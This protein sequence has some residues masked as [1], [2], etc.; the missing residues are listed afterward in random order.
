MR[1]SEQLVPVALILADVVPTGICEP[2][3]ILQIRRCEKWP[4]SES[5]GVVIALLD[6]VNHVLPI[7]RQQYARHCNDST[8]EPN[9]KGYALVHGVS[10]SFAASAS[11]AR[12]R[13]M[14]MRA[15]SASSISL[16][17]SAAV[18]IAGSSTEKSAARFF[19]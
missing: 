15:V 5:I 1:H 7:E 14:R 8:D 11:N 10:G 18:S 16:R 12:L 6:G 13:S 3:N 17:C 2:D 9:V 4:E 19:S